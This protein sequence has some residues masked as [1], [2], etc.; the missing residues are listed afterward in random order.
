MGTCPSLGDWSDH[1]QSTMVSYGVLVWF[2][3][4]QYGMVWYIIIWELIIWYGV[5]RHEMQE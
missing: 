4:L 2:G 3:L 1:P 5:V